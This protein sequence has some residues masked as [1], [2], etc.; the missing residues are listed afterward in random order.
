MA[1][2]QMDPS[3]LTCQVGGIA[4]MSINKLVYNVDTL[5][6]DTWGLGQWAWTRYRGKGGKHTWVVVCYQPVYNDK[7]PL[8]VYNQHCLHFLS[9]DMDGCPRQLYMQHL[10]QAIVKWQATGDTLIIGG[11]WNADTTHSSWTKFWSDLGLYKPQKGGNGAPEA[12]YN[13]GTLQVDTLYVS[14]HLRFFEFEIIPISDSICGADHKA[15]LIRVHKMI[16]G[17][18]Q[19]PQQQHRGRC[20]KIQDPWVQHRY[21]TTLKKHCHQQQL[22][23]RT[24]KLWHSTTLGQPLTPYQQ[25]EYEDIDSLKVQAMQQAKQCCCKLRMGEVKWLPVLAESRAQI[26]MWTA[27]V[28]ARSG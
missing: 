19:L 6:A 17:I 12:T 22:F 14:P 4:L 11:D 20:L 15:L 18:G 1:W 10:Q 3:P 26:A 23:Q 13:Q 25:A 27:L 16:L 9:K 5:G 28:K 2:N 7:G 8:L 24:L 21:N